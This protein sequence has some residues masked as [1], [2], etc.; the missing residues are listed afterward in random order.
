MNDEFDWQ[1]L[2]IPH[3]EAAGRYVGACV[4][5]CLFASAS[6]RE[7]QSRLLPLLQNFVDTTPGRYAWYKTNVMKRCSTLKADA[8]L[9]LGEVIADANFLKPGDL[10]L[11]IHSGSAENDFQSPSV[12]FFSEERFSK[13][14]GMLCR[15][16]VRLTIPT[17]PSEPRKWFDF[18]T[19]SASTVNFDCGYCGY[20]WYWNGGDTTMERTWE[21]NKG[22][23][24]NHP[25]MGY[26]DPFSFLPFI[27]QGLI[28]TGWLTLIG[29]DL[30]KR[31]GSVEISKLRS[32]QNVGVSELSGDSG[33]VLVAGTRPVVGSR[34]P[35]DAQFLEPYRLV[36]K[37]L[38]CISLSDSD[39][40]LLDLAG[41]DDEAEILSW[42]RRFF[43]EPRA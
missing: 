1:S 30:M 2:R 9:L 42:Y 22:L 14:G 37:S 40:Q 21:R 28:Q 11:E 19:A 39:A 29:N 38:A 7:L 23:L 8:K 17:T 27:G 24:L 3:P 33:I 10:G 32:L 12:D 43:D 36:G 41:F 4:E 16:M 6:R 34:L 13:S 5:I 31:L 26:H 18:F 25:A 20:S 35:E 15:T